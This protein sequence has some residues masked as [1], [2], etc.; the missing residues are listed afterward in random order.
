M[1]IYP[2]EILVS[3]LARR[4][5]TGELRIKPSIKRLFGFGHKK[6]SV[7]LPS[8]IGMLTAIKVFALSNEEIVQ[9]HTMYPFFHPFLTNVQ[10]KKVYSAMIDARG[11]AIHLTAG[12]MASVVRYNQDLKLCPGCV[13]C[14]YEE[15]GEPYWHLTHQLPGMLVCPKHFYKLISYCS[16]CGEGLAEYS[17][18]TLPLGPSYCCNGHDLTAQAER[19]YDEKAIQVSSAILRVYELA[20]SGGFKHRNF[21]S[22][23]QQRL[24]QLGLCSS[25]GRMEQAQIAQMFGRFYSAD[26]LSSV[27]VP[28][29]LGADTWLSCI[30]RAP[31]RAFH[32]LLHIL[33]ILCLWRDVDRFVEDHKN[34]ED[35]MTTRYRKI[36]GKRCAMRNKAFRIDWAKRDKQVGLCI[37]K[38]ILEIRSAPGKPQRLTISRIGRHIKKLAILERHLDKLPICRALLDRNLETEVQHQM[39][40][41]DWAIQTLSVNRECLTKWRVL[42]K[43]SIR[44]YA[45]KD[46]ETYLFSCL[47]RVVDVA[48]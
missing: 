40:K 42:R 36:V 8:S 46:V 15:Y 13:R 28:F 38:A 12:I 44:V 3:A 26:L 5:N 2:D 30:L 17:R 47:K 29:P 9:E 19:G 39:R 21:H 4:S 35:V 7:D 33:V 11:S 16:V 25:K 45:S 20:K 27:G 34:V 14:D 31:R 41:I 43:A 48:A 6:I 32:P 10:T 22:I 1:E 18:S 37:N 23:Y 24:K